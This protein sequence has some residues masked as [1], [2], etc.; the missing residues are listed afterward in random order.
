MLERLASR[1]TR[2][3][4]MLAISLQIMLPGMVSVAQANGIELGQY[5]CLI[6]GEEP[7]DEIKDAARRIA[8]IVGD[9]PEEEPLDAEHCPFCTIAHG[10]PLPAC[11]L[12]TIP[13]SFAL[14]QDFVLYEPGLL[15]PA[16]GPPLGSRGPPSHI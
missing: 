5:I 3:L 1:V 15:I 14:V 13:L 2:L 6:P 4:A 11:T 16:Q 10:A 9:I 7:S 8:E 12:V